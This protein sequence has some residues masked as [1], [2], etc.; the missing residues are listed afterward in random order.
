MIQASLTVEQFLM[1]RADL[2]DAGQ[3]SELIRGVAVA[4]DPPDL[5]HGNTVLNLSKALSSYVHAG[6][7][8]EGY[9]C[10]DLGLIV[11][12]APDTVFFPAMSFFVGGPRFAEADREVTDTVPA[13][14]AELISTSDRRIGIHDKTSAY[15]RKG[16]GAVWHVDPVQRVVLVNRAHQPV[17]RLTEFETLRDEALPSFSVK[18]AELFLEPKWAQ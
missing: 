10:F 2:P 15:F 14:V 8:P 9:P 12:R 16:V 11:E 1:T 5:E 3:W 13:L 6:H 17:Q 4:L 18:V 7:L